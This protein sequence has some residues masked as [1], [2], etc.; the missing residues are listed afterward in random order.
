MPRGTHVRAVHFRMTY[1]NNLTVSFRIIERERRPATGWPRSY[2]KSVILRICIGKVAHRLAGR[3]VRAHSVWATIS[4]S[5]H[6]TRI[7]FDF[8]PEK[9]EFLHIRRRLDCVKGASANLRSRLHNGDIQHSSGL[10]YE[11]CHVSIL[12]SF[13][14]GCNICFSIYLVIDIYWSIIESP[15][16]RKTFLISSVNILDFLVKL[17]F[18]V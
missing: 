5:N 11:Q 9:W 2:R 13:Y 15:Y 16:E 3:L 1:I 8:I 6:D 10:F 4:F 12:R 14:T 18:L 7:L 17:S